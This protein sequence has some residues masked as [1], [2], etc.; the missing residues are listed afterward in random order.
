MTLYVI[1]GPPAAGKTTYVTEHAK[2]GD[3]RIDYDA[4]ANLLAGQA[5]D[6]HSHSTVVKAITKATRQA[7]IDAAL[8]HSGRRD[9]WIIDTAPSTTALATYRKHHAEIITIDPGRETVMHRIK[10]HRPKGLLAVA[11]RWYEQHDKE[12]AAAPTWQ[13]KAKGKRKPRQR[14][15]AEATPASKTTLTTTQRGLGYA[16]QQQRKRTLAKL[17]DGDPCWWC[18]RPMHKDQALHADHSTS[19]AH[20]GRHADRMLHAACN[21]QRQDGRNDHRRPALKTTGGLQAKP[22][23]MATGGIDHRYPVDDG[24]QGGV[25]QF[26]WKVLTQ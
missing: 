4:I 14:P 20:G 16:H 10:Q 24:A 12:K 7:A 5:A 18:G 26:N 13:T 8:H 21:T 11:A 6:N 22:I 9:V 17:I 19:R 25:A 15:T 2:R 23:R 1:T 3:I